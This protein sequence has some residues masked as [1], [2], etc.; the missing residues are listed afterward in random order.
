MDQPTDLQIP[1]CS[2]QNKSEITSKEQK[3]TQ[4][5]L[6]K[7]TKIYFTEV[8]IELEHWCLPKPA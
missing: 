1:I 3:N 8:R 5:Y 4:K 6:T 7:Y 2:K